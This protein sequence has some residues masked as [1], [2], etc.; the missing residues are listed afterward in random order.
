MSYFKLIL[1]SFYKFFINKNLYFFAALILALL[2][3]SLNKKN[4][5]RVLC[6]NKSI[7][8]N[9]LNEIKN[10]DGNLQ[11]LSFPRLLL[12]EIIKKYVK[13]FEE[14][15]DSS[16][17]SI[18]NGTLEQEKILK[19]MK[20]LFRYLHFF[21]RFDA[22]FA[23]NYVYVS[24][25]EF[26][27][28]AKSNNI[29]VIVL[30]KEG[31]GAALK[32]TNKII[33]KMYSGKI[34]L[35]DNILFYNSFIKNMLLKAKVPGIHNKNTHVVGIPRLDNYLNFDFKSNDN[36]HI[37]LFL[38]E[39]DIKA[40]RFVDDI[41]R[42]ADYIK[43][44]ELFQSAFVKF[45]CENPE[46]SLTIKSKNNP[47]AKKSLVKILEN[48][49]IESLP[50]N[51]QFT[52][53]LDPL[54]LI[55]KSKYIAGSLSTTLLEALLLDKPIFCPSYNDIIT[56]GG[57]DFFDNHPG[58]VN[59]V[60]SFGEVS[61][62]ILGKIKIN[63]ANK[64]SKKLILKPLMYKIDGKA[65]LRTSQLLSKIIEKKLIKKI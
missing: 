15:N 8:S 57:V 55:Q 35:G 9:D 58:A 20:S 63:I 43:R 10:V 40:D 16:Y 32:T 1:V 19:A 6:L 23:G 45:C 17:H 51:I 56:G 59:Y 33:D 31:I 60:K 18:M 7:F 24:Q 49:H 34:F 41:T 21:L 54:E 2:T 44:G 36:K 30:Y 13:N 37:T 38:F 65:S 50:P 14:L 27:K 46:Y 48:N 64:E 61:D 29:P 11:F 47:S 39:P 4:Q 52:S 12:S 42:K 22:V 5:Y 3:K 25:Q 26:F 62:L 53:K 28:V